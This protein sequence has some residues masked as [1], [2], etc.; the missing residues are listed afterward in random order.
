MPKILVFGKTG[1]LASCLAMCGDE[2]PNAELVFVGRDEC[3]LEDA[4]QIEPVINR[5]Q[6]DIVI[7][8]AAYTAVDLAEEQRDIAFKVNRDAVR[9]MAEASAKRSVP[10]IHVST[11][12][13]FDGQASKP[14]SE[15]DPVSPL[16]VYG[17]SKYAG[18][19]AVREANEKHLIIRTSWVFS[20]FGKNFVKTMLN[21][22]AGRDEIRVV[23]DQTGCPTSADDLARAI[24][25]LC[26]M[27]V[28]TDFKKFG[29]YH[30]SSDQPQT[31]FEFAKRIQKVA[32][33]V[34]GAD[35]KGTNCRITPVPSSE[36]PTVAE[37]P[38]YSVM[39]SQRFIDAFAIQLPTVEESLSAVIEN[40]PREK[41]DA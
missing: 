31:W 36:Y 15:Q 19:V 41:S 40:L 7:N 30:L 34:W 12:Y 26:E 10:L 3:D 39:S 5:V 22:M 8:A 2:F 32:S 33:Q 13:V 27:A 18:E 25:K 37:R 35:W 29:T 20:P 4:R 1:Q 9:A 21:L 38:K 28:A 16:G 23:N 14:Y 6:P 17:E 11:D 24:L